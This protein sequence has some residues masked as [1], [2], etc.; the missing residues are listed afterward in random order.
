MKSLHM[1]TWILLIVGG[2]NWGLEAFGY[3]LVEMIFNDGSTLEMLVYLLV[4]LSAVYELV[5]H[6]KNCRAC[7]SGGM[8]SG[9]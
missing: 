8:Q 3:N 6:K 7:G 4:G 5:T 9:M 2:L 1:V